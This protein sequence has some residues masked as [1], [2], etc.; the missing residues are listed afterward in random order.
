MLDTLIHVAVAPLMLLGTVVVAT[1]VHYTMLQGLVRLLDL[2]SHGLL[3]MC[4]VTVGCLLAH[5]IEISC[6][7][8]SYFLLG[9]VPGAGTIGVGSRPELFDCLYLSAQTF[10]AA[11]YGDIV[12]FGLERVIAVGE[13]LCGLL[14]LGWS[15]TFGMRVRQRV[16]LLRS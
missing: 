9:L 5:A 11:G 3:R 4:V 8:L 12:A 1:G 13:S 10:S 15:V 14:L 2:V 16:E 6:F 7:A